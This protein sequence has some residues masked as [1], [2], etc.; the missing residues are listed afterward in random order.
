MGR[1]GDVHPLLCGKLD[2]FAP[3]LASCPCH[4]P[5]PFVLT[6][7]LLLKCFIWVAKVRSPTP[8]SQIHTFSSQTAPPQVTFQPI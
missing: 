5:S 3:L 7:M 4:C 2:I 6:K 1:E 8:F